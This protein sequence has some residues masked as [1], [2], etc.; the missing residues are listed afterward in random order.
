MVCGPFKTC[1]FTSLFSSTLQC[2]P[3]P[4]RVRAKSHNG[5]LTCALPSPCL[6]PS[7]LTHSIPTTWLLLEHT[8]YSP[9]RLLHL[10]FSMSGMLPPR[11]SGRFVPSSLQALAQ[12]L[13]RLT[14]KTYICIKALTNFYFQQLC[15][16]LTLI[17]G[18]SMLLSQSACHISFIS[19]SMFP[20]T[21]NLSPIRAKTLY[22]F[23]AVLQCLKLCLAQKFE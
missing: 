18:S 11:I 16:L 4:F 14:L 5:L 2:F 8:K 6:L 1:L 21:R 13:E 3:I 22:L 9:S 10:L 7:S 20:L 15:I 19:L 23:I 12:R 17:T